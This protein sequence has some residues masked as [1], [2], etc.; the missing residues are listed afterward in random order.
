MLTLCGRAIQENVSLFLLG[1]E[2]NVLERMQERFQREFPGL[3]IAG[4]KP[5]P[6]R[7]LIEAENEAITHLI[8]Q[9]GAGIVLVSLGCPKQEAWIAQQQGKIQ[10]VMIGLGGA[11]PVYAGLKRRAPYPIQ[12]AGLEWLYRLLQEP[13]RLWGRYTSTIPLFLWLA[14]KQLFQNRKHPSKPFAAID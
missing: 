14:L 3:Q 4:V 12:A 9:S 1:S 11:F 2:A 8:N 13:G 7:P 10:A 5:L 6:F